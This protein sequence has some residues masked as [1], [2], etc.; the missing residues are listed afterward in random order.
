MVETALAL[1]I[2]MSNVDLSLVRESPGKLLND[3]D[4]AMSPAG[5]PHSDREIDST[6]GTVA[7]NQ[8]SQKILGTLQECV[9]SIG[10]R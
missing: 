6:F 3:G 7:G 8:K 2:A 9:S 5:A 1:D 4:G 10:G